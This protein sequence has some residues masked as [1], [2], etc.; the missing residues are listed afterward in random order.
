[1]TGL[2]RRQLACLDFIRGCH[3]AHGVAPSFVEI[4]TAL[5][6][7]STSSAHRLVVSLEA[8]GA[9]TRLRGRKRSVVPVARNAVTVDLP[10][11]LER[12]VQ[13]LARR[14]GTTPAAVIIACLRDRST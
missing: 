14:A 2:T 4:C 13:D 10:P 11:D 7:R 6:L 12:H 9:V 8:R 3:L 5:R 1:M